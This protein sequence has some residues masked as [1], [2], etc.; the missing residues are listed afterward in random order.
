MLSFGC[1]MDGVTVALI[2]F[3]LSLVLNFFANLIAWQVTGIA[4]LR[5]WAISNLLT[6]SG[7]GFLFLFKVIPWKGLLLLQNLG[8]F[9]SIMLVPAGLFSYRGLRFH[10][11]RHSAL[12]A[13]GLAAMSWALWWHDSFSLRVALASLFL[14]AYSF[15]VAYLI[16]HHTRGRKTLMAF[17]V[18]A[19]GI[20]GIINL[21]RL[22]MSA[23]GI[24]LND[25]H[26][27]QGFTYILVFVF[28]PVCATG[29]YF[30]L[31][32]L[33]VQRLVDEKNS[34]LAAAERLALQYRELSDHDPLTNALNS[35]SF[36]AELSRLL[37]KSRSA[38]APLCVL[39][40]DLDHFKRINDTY[41][42][43]AGDITLKHAVQV[44]QGLLRPADCLGRVGGE[45]FA[46]ILPNT[47]RSEAAH[48]AE[49][50]R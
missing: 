8:Y 14:T 7:L 36:M 47:D 11:L 13:A 45:E 17:A 2:T 21:V 9:L 32:L 27:F 6:F 24:G 30:G 50:L 4:A 42:H 22:V 31:I 48:V 26:P 37:E 1:F 23:A 18:G 39:M 29:G 40:A 25:G 43:A 34:S 19:W 33:I 35:R 5:L 38:Q 20:Y 28:A 3:A 46:I 16:L 12:I 15:Y 44:W 10:W 41:G 49:R